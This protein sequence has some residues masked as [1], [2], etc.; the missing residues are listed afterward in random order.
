VKN[1]QK[2]AVLEVEYLRPDCDHSCK[3]GMQRQEKCQSTIIRY[4]FVE[5]FS[6]TMEYNGTKKG[7]M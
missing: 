4:K 2:H 7:K 1:S 3:N 5:R 6:I